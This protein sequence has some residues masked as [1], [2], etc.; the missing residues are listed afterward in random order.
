M[1]LHGSNTNP[2]T[3]TSAASLNFFT[4]QIDP[5]SGTTKSYRPTAG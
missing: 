4:V 2:T 1:T 3:T 5:V